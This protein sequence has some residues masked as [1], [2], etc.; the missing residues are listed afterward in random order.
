M[1]K[2]KVQFNVPVPGESLTAELG[3]R[4]WQTPSKLTT[5]DEAIDYYMERM[6]SEDFMEQV[7]DVLESGVPVATIANTLQLASVMDGIHTVDVGML[8]APVIMEMMM[9]LGDSAG[10]KY[11][12]G[13]EEEKE[14]ISDAKIAKAVSSYKK[15]VK[16]KDLAKPKEVET[17]EE[18]EVEDEPAGL[19]ARRK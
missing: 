8:V 10:I 6:S 12:T 17:K 16:E 2:D 11:Q 19:M 5:V 14:E 4:P 9:L 7:V 13:L 18:P 15:T 1:L 3:G